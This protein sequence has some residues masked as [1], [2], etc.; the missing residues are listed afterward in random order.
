[1]KK[2]ISGSSP[3]P[4]YWSLLFPYQSGWKVAFGKGHLV[5]Y[6][7]SRPAR[8][9]GPGGRACLSRGSRCTL[10]E[11][12]GIKVLGTAPCLET[13]TE[14]GP[15]SLH[16]DQKQLGAARKSPRQTR[17]K[18]QPAGAPG[19]RGIWGIWWAGPIFRPL[20][21]PP[22]FSPKSGDLEI[23]KFRVD[24]DGRNFKGDPDTSLE[25][26]TFH[27]DSKSPADK[28][29]RGRSF[30]IRTQLFKIPR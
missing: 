19:E 9:V 22:P 17:L 6:P 3:P 23:R 10:R 21:R 5:V 14:R 11:E 29:S 20:F 8:W 24:K 15:I 12:V 16:L 4:P 7:F 18:L 26:L 28:K 30:K 13:A 2:W 1:M 27:W 25:I